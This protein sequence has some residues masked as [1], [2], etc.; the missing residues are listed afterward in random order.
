MSSSPT[1][2]AALAI[3]NARIWTADLRRP[4][5]DALLVRDG[6][7]E[8]LGSSAEVRKR[9][10]STVPVVDARGGMLLPAWVDARDADGFAAVVA[11]ARAGRATGEPLRV[12]SAA[13]L[14]LLDRDLSRRDAAGVAGIALMLRDGAVLADPAGLVPA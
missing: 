8:L 9:A 2:P 11:A 1:R 5:A 13:D 6:R 10:G 14:T 7:V 4:W 12:G 3:V